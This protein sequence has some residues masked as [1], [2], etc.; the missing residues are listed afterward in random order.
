MYENSGTHERMPHI[1]DKQTEQYTELPSFS[2][3]AILRK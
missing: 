3:I 1:K 2:K